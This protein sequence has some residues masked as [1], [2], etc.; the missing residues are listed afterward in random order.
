MST[1]ESEVECLRCQAVVLREAAAEHQR[2]AEM[3]A[4]DA[5]VCEQQA[6]KLDELLGRAPQLRIGVPDTGLRGRRLRDSAIEVLARAGRLGTPIHY[7]EWYSLLTHD[8][9]TVSGQDPLATFLTQISRSPVV[10]RAEGE[11]G[12]YLL[13]PDAA[14]REATRDLNDARNAQRQAQAA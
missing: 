7:R 1:T 13:D 11:S 2:Q 10:Q 9:S 14:G 3:L 6:K 4:A 12:V 8:G 5:L